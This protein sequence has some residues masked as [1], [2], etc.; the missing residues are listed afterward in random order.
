ME[1]NLRL[2][3]TEYFSVQRDMIPVFFSVGGL[4]MKW[5]SLVLHEDFDVEHKQNTVG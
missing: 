4:A 5:L 3:D 2:T 1:I